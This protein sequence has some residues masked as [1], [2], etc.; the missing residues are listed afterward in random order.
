MEVRTADVVLCK[1]SLAVRLFLTVRD[2]QRECASALSNGGV[3]LKSSAAEGTSDLFNLSHELSRPVVRITQIGVDP[4]QG[5]CLGSFRIHVLT[6]D[7]LQTPMPRH[8]QTSSHLA[9]LTVSVSSTPP[10]M[11]STKRFAK[12]SSCGDGQNTWLSNELLNM[13]TRSM[14]VR[15]SNDHHDASVQSIFAYSTR[16]DRVVTTWHGG[17]A[18]KIWVVAVRSSLL[19]LSR[20]DLVSRFQTVST[21]AATPVLS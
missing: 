20:R 18:I 17:F 10:R 8:H 12:Q 5:Y 11:P 19:H 4:T 16:G 15:R 7:G 21:S 6:K 14:D 2:E 3:P 1:G 13:M 9:C